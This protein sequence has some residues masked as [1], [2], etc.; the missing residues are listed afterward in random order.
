MSQPDYPETVRCPECT[1][2]YNPDSLTAQQREQMNMCPWCNPVKKEIVMTNIELFK[3]WVAGAF[4]SDS[5][6]QVTGESGSPDEQEYNISI[7]TFTNEYR[8][9]AKERADG[10]YLGCIAK[11]RYPRAGENWCRGNDL[12]DGK[13]TEE[14]WQEILA[15][16]VRYELQTIPQTMSTDNGKSTT[17]AK[18]TIRKIDSRLGTGWTK[19]LAKALRESEKE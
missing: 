9:V 7:F 13:L 14:T 6:V 4:Q 10:G 19:E 1:H 11:C 5:L 15:G 12:P 2:P 8:I 3:Q 18:E 17:D 16:I